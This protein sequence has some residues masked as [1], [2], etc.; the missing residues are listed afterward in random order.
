MIHETIY[1]GRDNAVSVGLRADGR[2]VNITGTVRMTIHIGGVDNPH[3]VLDSRLVANVFDWTTTG[4]TGRLTLSNLGHIE[5]LK[6]GEYQSRLTLYD[7]TY[8][9]GLGWDDMILEV[10]NG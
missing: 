6:V 8:P 7:A 3:Y 9:N 1:K 2:N 10:V 5:A 4:A